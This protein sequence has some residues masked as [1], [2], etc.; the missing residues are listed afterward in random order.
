MWVRAII[1]VY[2]HAHTTFNPNQ[3]PIFNTTPHKPQMQ[4]VVEAPSPITLA[5]AIKNAQELEGM[6]QARD[7][8]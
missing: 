1:D 7:F 8:I 5:K 3:M 6:R 4:R 2:L